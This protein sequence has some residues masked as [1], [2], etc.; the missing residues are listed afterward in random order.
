VPTVCVICF[1]HRIYRILRIDWL[2]A[3][4]TVDNASDDPDVDAG[5]GCLKDVNAA[6]AAAY[7]TQGKWVPSA[8]VDADPYKY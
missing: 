3:R 5:R 8:V 4:S 1:Q 6:I 2:K 7:S